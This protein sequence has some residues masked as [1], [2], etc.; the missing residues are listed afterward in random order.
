VALIDRLRRV[1][2]DSGM[3]GFGV[4]DA[5]PFREVRA[6]LEGRVADGSSASLRFTFADPGRSTDV[7]RSF[8]WARRLV[9]VAW[10]YLPAAGHPGPARAGTGRAA[11]F[12]TEDHYRGLRAG[13]QA[14]AELLRDA[15]RRA[16]VLADDNR[17]VDRAAAVR[18]GVGWWAKNAQVLM[19]GF[20]P[21]TLLGS[22][23]TDAELTA[24]EPMWRDC[25]TCSAC[26]P[27]CPTGALVAPGILDARRCLAYWVQ[28]PGVIPR[29]LR[30]ALGDRLY[31]CDDCLEACPPGRRMLDGSSAERGRVDLVTVLC[32]DD[33]T[34]R[35][36]F[37]HWYVPRNDVR[38]LRRNALV[39][40]G[41]VGGRDAV[42]IAAGFAAHPDWLLRAHAA[43]ALG[44]LGGTAARRAL[45]AAARRERNPHVRAEIDGTLGRC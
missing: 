35:R 40:L 42:G 7:R 2:R 25:G 37:A 13:L 20:G 39:A 3:C 4:A 34:L 24:T 10:P 9:V 15:G 8:P 22:V 18:A 38:H 45:H 43:W 23:V 36:R 33:R 17:L 16:A 12:A 21:W 31:G 26:L 6:Q 1:A 19:P 5:G 14:I 28:A 11:R 44:E 29:P 41:N 27:A 32:A 30:R